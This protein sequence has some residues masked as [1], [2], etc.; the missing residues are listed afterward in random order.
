M[1]VRKILSWVTYIPVIGSAIMM[2][3]GARGKEISGT[4]LVGSQKLVHL[5]FGLM[6]LMIDI[7]LIE[8]I[9]GGSIVKI[10][11]KGFIRRFLVV[12]ARKAGARTATGTFLRGGARVVGK[13]GGTVLGRVA[14]SAAERKIRKG[15]EHTVGKIHGARIDP[16]QRRELEEQ[17]GQKL[18]R[19]DT[20][21][22]QKAQR[23]SEKGKNNANIPEQ[24]AA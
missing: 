23:Q 5:L 18:N 15:V 11:G 13:M 1:S 9:A 22:A 10:F 14:I 3:E 24:M 16:K 4:V 21:E 8:T 12:G 7:L 2:W 19:R 17:F 6:F 20:I